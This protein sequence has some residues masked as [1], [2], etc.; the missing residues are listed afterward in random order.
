MDVFTV[1]E[2]EPELA[3]ASRGTAVVTTA[4]RSD[5]PFILRDPALPFMDT[6]FSM[7]VSNLDPH[8]VQVD[9]FADLI[10][11]N[12]QV[13]DEIISITGFFGIMCARGEPVQLFVCQASP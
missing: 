12:G 2:P 11:E 10:D 5:E 7:R 4:P 1:L 8:W 3:S 13:A 9:I 6:S